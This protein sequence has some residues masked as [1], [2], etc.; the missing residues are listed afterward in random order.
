MFGTKKNVRN[1]LNV[2]RAWAMGKDNRGW[3]HE[4]FQIPVVN[5]DLSTTWL[6]I[7]EV[8]VVRTDPSH[9]I[10][11]VQPYSIT[12]LDRLFLGSK[13]LG[14]ILAFNQ[15]V[16]NF[17]AALDAVNRADD[18]DTRWVRTLLL[19][20]GTIGTSPGGGLHQMY[21]DVELLL[22]KEPQFAF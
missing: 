6:D 7:V 5:A 9:V 22:P 4:D 11:P 1:Y 12:L 10:F 14:A 3:L 17:N 18:N 15:A 19:H 13:L 21:N 16:S 20:V 2:V 8:R